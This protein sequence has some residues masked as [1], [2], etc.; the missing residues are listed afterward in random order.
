M[1]RKW[2]IG[3]IYLTLF[4]LGGYLSFYQS[5]LIQ[6]M[7]IFALNGA[8]MGAAVGAQSAGMMIAPLILGGASGKIGKNKVILIAY[9]LMIAGAFTA[10]MARGFLAFLC[11]GFLIGAGF[12]VLEATL[13]A[14][15]ADAFASRS[16]RHLNFSQA[17]FSIGALCGPILTA[18][19]LERGVYFQCIY[20]VIAVSFFLLGTLFFLAQRGSRAEEHVNERITKQFAAFFRNRLLLL[21]AV[22]VGIYVGVENASA[23][24]A[25]VYFHAEANRSAY[26]AAALSVFWGAMI[27]S[28]YLAGTLKLR[29]KAMLSISCAITC[30][31]LVAAMLMTDPLAKLTMFALCGFGCGPIWPLLM[32]RAARANRGSSGLV[33]NVMLSFCSLGGVLLPVLAGWISDRSG[34]SGVYY[35]CACATAAILL[36]YTRA[37]RAR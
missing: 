13:S 6:A 21:L 16:V 34:V 10:G 12:A 3:C 1:R 22:A 17:T 36:L 37:E 28:R 24:F 30:T 20:P 19:V 4:S 9:G 29:V 14:L 27:P 32:N 2:M 26:S 8:R 25:E 18:A 11:G 23:S 31:G 15:L 5:T 7:D 33:L 35:F